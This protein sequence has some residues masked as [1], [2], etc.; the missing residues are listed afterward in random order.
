MKNIFSAAVLLFSLCAIN[1]CSSDDGDVKKTT[2]PPVEETPDVLTVAN[3][4]SYMSDP[5]A[6]DETVALFYNLK[7]LSKTKFIIGQ[8]DAFNGFYNNAGG[9]SD[10]KKATGNDPAL[11]G[12][13]FM[14]ITDKQN[15]GQPDNWFY[16][17][18]LKITSDVKAA[19][20]KGMV[21]IFCWHLR[22]PY[23]QDTFYAADITDPVQK[24]NAFKS[25]LPGGENHDLYKSKLDKVAQVLNNLTDANGKLIPVLFRPFH[26]FDGN[27]FW[28]GAAYCTPDE[29]KQAWQFTVTYLRDTKNVHNVLYA[30]SPDNSYSTSSQYLSRYP[31][32]GYVDV[33]GID[34]YGDFAN[35]STNGVNTANTK[36]RMISDMAI[37][38]VKIAAMTETGYRVTTTTS[39]IPNFFSNNIYSA[40]TANNVELAFVMF[41][42]NNQDGY[43]VPPSGQTDTQDFKNFTLKSE[44]VLENNIPEMYVL[45]AN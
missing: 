20:A 38:K 36:L 7:K 6:T 43:Y 18:E 39:P 11:L 19:Y 26:E 23:N 21:N 45:P 4:R 28:W 3:V 17:Q 33:L 37:E 2:N 25:I 29:Y 15:N 34:N 30:F 32:D 27:W 22:E 10:I 13:D 40:M 44:S 8:Q 14:F 41:W 9:N 1:S 42:A 5:N 35:G 12:S 16:Q 24:A 31:G